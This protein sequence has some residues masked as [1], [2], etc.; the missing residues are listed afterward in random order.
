M[1]ANGGNPVAVATGPTEQLS[2]V[3]MADGNGLTYI[4]YP[5]SG[6]NVRRDASG[7]WGK[8]TFWFNGY[9]SA[10]YA[11]DGSGVLVGVF[12]KGT[13]CPSCQPG[14]YL[15]D[16]DQRNP[17]MVQVPLMAQAV[18]SPGTMIYSR[19]SRHAYEINREKDGTAAIWQLPINGD[20]EKRLVHFSDPERQPYRTTIDVDAHNFYFNIGDRQSDVYTMELKKQ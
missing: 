8:P 16:S 14:L 15:L 9:G 11:P 1:D 17:R 10:A 4:V 5:S 2:P 7:K 19:D 18:A 6:Y 3:W 20:P 12:L 13:L